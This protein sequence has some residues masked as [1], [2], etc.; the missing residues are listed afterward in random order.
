[1]QSAQDTVSIITNRTT[2]MEKPRSGPQLS[3]DA[4]LKTKPPGTEFRGPETGRQKSPFG[5]LETCRDQSPGS[6]TPQIPAESARMRAFLETRGLRR[7]RGGRIRAQTWDPLFKSQRLQGP[8]AGE[9]SPNLLRTAPVSHQ[10]RRQQ[11]PTNAIKIKRKRR[12]INEADQCP[13]AH[14]G[15]VAGSSP[16]GPT[17]LRP[18]GYAGRSHAKSK[19]KRV[20]RS[21]SEATAKTDH[22][23]R[24]LW[25]RCGPAL[26]SLRHSGKRS[27]SDCSMPAQ[28]PERE[29]REFAVFKIT[30][31]AKSARSGPSTR[32]RRQKRRARARVSQAPE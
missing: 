19:T 14:S 4:G 10:K 25:L 8:P 16:A 22:F 30:R 5:C 3:Q 11:D 21:L 7:L 15:L 28:G 13:P 17:T 24:V 6:E 31:L 27:D 26:R 12:K 32:A 23:Q 9:R 2:A 20:R 29:V 18:S 1:V